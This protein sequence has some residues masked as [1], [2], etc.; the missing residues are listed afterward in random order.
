MKWTSTGLLV[1]LAVSLSVPMA[2]RAAPADQTY[3][4]TVLESTPGFFDLPL[5]NTIADFAP[6]YHLKITLVTVTGGGGLA[7]EFEGGTGS[8]A[9]VGAD[10]PLRLAQADA[11]PGGV[12]IIGTNMTNMLYA[13]I[14]KKGSPYHTLADLKGRNVGITG[15]GA[16][17][18]VVLKWALITKAHMSP[19]DV[20]IVPLGPPETI[21]QA[22]LKGS[23]AA[24]TVFSPAL[25]EGLSSGQVQMVFDF[26]KY[27]Y[28]QNVF[29]VRTSQ[30]KADPTPFK[31][32]MQ[33][34]NAAVTKMYADPAYTLQSALHYWGQGTTEAVVKSELAFYMKYQWK[35]TDFPPSLYA[36]CRDVLLHSG[37]FPTADF[38]SYQEVTRY[39]PG[40]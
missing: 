23:V 19:S 4:L 24:G 6:R 18:E 28:A 21:L 40:N 14:A 11:I 32:F 35:G 26:R 7:T 16:A 20:R 22:V 27:P 29:M 9:M 1:W 36:A 17:S 15:A 38:P 2:A 33:A 8:I 37:D 10:T 39:A 12:T 34:Y 31:L 5:R 30:L 25:D 13:L 3:K